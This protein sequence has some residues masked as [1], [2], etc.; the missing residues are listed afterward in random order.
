MAVQRPVGQ[1]PLSRADIVT[2]LGGVAVGLALVQLT[3]GVLD[4]G[5]V[6]ATGGFALAA[7]AVFIGVF[8]YVRRAAIAQR[9]HAY[10]LLHVTAFLLVNASFWL[11]AMLAHS[12]TTADDITES[13][14]GA[15]LTMPLI[16]AV[17]LFLH[18]LGTVF[19]NGYEHVEV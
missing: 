5:K 18:T 13:W 6:T 3:I 15:L 14:R 16:W 17:G 4:D 2:Y 9:R 19:S 7:V 1:R 8:M 12:S 11:H 10:Y